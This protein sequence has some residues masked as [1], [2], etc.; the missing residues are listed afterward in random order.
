MKK[1]SLLVFLL[2]LSVLLAGC[3]GGETK[4]PKTTSKNNLANFSLAV[5]NQISG[6]V[7]LNNIP[8]G[9]CWVQFLNFDT[10]EKKYEIK[11]ELDGSWTLSDLNQNS[12]GKYYLQV[13]KNNQVVKIETNTTFYISQDMVDNKISF[14]YLGITDIGISEGGNIVTGSS[15][16]VNFKYNGTT[17]FVT[18]KSLL[19]IKDNTSDIPLINEPL[20]KNEFSYNITLDNV[21][22]LYNY[23]IID[24][25]DKLKTYASGTFRIVVVNGIK[26]LEVYS[27]NTLISSLDNINYNINY[28]YEEISNTTKIIPSIVSLSLSKTEI[29]N[30][31]IDTITFS[32]IV[33]DQNNKV[34]ENY[35]VTYEV[36]NEQNVSTKNITNFNSTILGLY[37]I[38]ATALYEDKVLSASKN[39]NVKEKNTTTLPYPEKI[40]YSAK[41]ITGYSV[42]VN[43]DFFLNVYINDQNG[44]RITD[45]EP[46]LYIDGQ[47][48]NYIGN[49]GGLYSYNLKQGLAKDYSVKIICGSLEENFT[50]TVTSLVGKTYSITI[51]VANVSP[52][53]SAEQFY[54][55]ILPYIKLKAEVDPSLSVKDKITNIKISSIK[56]VEATL[57]FDYNGTGDNEKVR[58]LINAVNPITGISIRKNSN[59]NRPLSLTI[60]NDM[61]IIDPIQGGK[62]Y[63]G[64]SLHYYPEQ[65]I[66]NIMINLKDSDGNPINLNNILKDNP[67]ALSVT[68]YSNILLSGEKIAPVNTIG[69][70]GFLYFIYSYNDFSGPITQLK[71][72]LKGYEV[73]DQISTPLKQDGVFPDS[74]L[75]VQL[76]KLTEDLSFKLIKTNIGY[77]VNIYNGVDGYNNPIYT[78]NNVIYSKGFFLKRKSDL[79]YI[80]ISFVK[81]ESPVGINLQEPLTEEDKYKFD[82][83]FTSEMNNGSYETNVIYMLIRA[84]VLMNGE[85]KTQKYS[86]VPIATNSVAFTPIITEGLTLKSF[87]K[88]LLS[89]NKITEV[90]MVA[91]ERF[92]PNSSEMSYN[93]NIKVGNFKSIDTSIGKINTL[94]AFL[95][96][97]KERFGV[98]SFFIDTYI[99]S[100]ASLNE[101]SLSMEDEKT[102]NPNQSI[103]NYINDIAKYTGIGYFTR[104]LIEDNKFS[105]VSNI[106]EFKDYSSSGITDFASTPFNSSIFSFTNGLT[107]E[108][109]NNDLS[110]DNNINNMG[111]IMNVYNNGFYADAIK[112]IHNN[113]EGYIVKT[114]LKIQPN[115]ANIVNL[116]TDNQFNTNSVNIYDENGLV[117]KDKFVIDS[118]IKF[119][120]SKTENNV[121]SIFSDKTYKTRVM[122]K[123]KQYKYTYSAGKMIYNDS[124]IKDENFEGIF[125]SNGS[126]DNMNPDA[127]GYLPMTA[128]TPEKTNNIDL[129]NKLA[130]I[131]GATPGD[132]VLSRDFISGSGGFGQNINVSVS[133]VPL[134][135]NEVATKIG[136]GLMALGSAWLIYDNFFDGDP[137]LTGKKGEGISWNGG[138]MDNLRF[139]S[140]VAMIGVGGFIATSINDYAYDESDNSSWN[141]Q[142][143]LNTSGEKELSNAYPNGLMEN[144]TSNNENA[145]LWY[146]NKWDM[147]VYVP[148]RMPT[149]MLLPKAKIRT[150][151]KSKVKVLRELYKVK[152]DTTN[153]STFEIIAKTVDYSINGGG[154]VNEG[155]DNL[156]LDTYVDKGWYKI[157]VGF[158]KVGCADKN[159][160]D[161]TLPLPFT[162]TRAFDT[163]D[164]KEVRDF[165]GNNNYIYN[166][167]PYG[168]GN[169]IVNSAISK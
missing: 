6:K 79:K 47:K 2:I 108:A 34:I 122:Y 5:N 135:Q 126:I 145:Q 29:L 4:T 162:V 163:K 140:Q 118:N 43:K 137:I 56:G 125:V 17:S 147:Y 49:L 103:N 74:A 23:Y 155:V 76:T 53:G 52:N 35:P 73:L 120:I 121:Y 70:N 114:N 41:D 16:K 67:N 112:N 168:N 37:T 33:F 127:Y 54:S 153:G 101:D 31:G 132:L 3:L 149:K 117:S 138:T 15:F 75:N 60:N 20:L 40:L 160:W 136:A 169:F 152:P 9:N 144:I 8:Q 104:T 80:P 158:N 119:N 55:N 156:S 154:A 14:F 69:N 61:L 150:S 90:N 107:L 130:T 92:G 38:K 83:L 63:E 19:Y 27:G 59:E 106:G 110:I 99:K 13:I 102:D 124:D 94:N 157:K 82:F 71:I 129:D 46:T 84:D 96:I 123:K 62:L 88:D 98:S 39:I 48:V 148:Y 167:Y 18:A 93:G 115:G 1:K 143:I 64:Q 164:S 77:S 57:S 21:N 36:I 85:I 113:N 78:P 133:K 139:A 116:L 12:V 30:D 165:Y 32:S 111:F 91:S 89:D 87:N 86:L 22:K 10:K 7:L 159:G 66:G 50:Y 11:T 45:K 81:N 141:N 146:M 51:K 28:S 68:G 44:N 97:Y 26:S 72:G 142:F 24:N 25:E 100:G 161:I 58:F 128:N 131:K 109:T 166:Y 95:S 65:K 134:G 42:E 105:Q 151:F